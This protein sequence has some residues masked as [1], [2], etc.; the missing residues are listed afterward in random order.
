MEFFRR[1]GIADEIR[2]A[3]LPQDHPTDVVY[4]T[5]WRG[6]ELTRYRLPPSSMAKTK[7][8]ALDDSWPTPEPQHRICQIYL[9][10]ILRRKA[11]SMPGLEFREGWRFESYDAS[12][13]GVVA[14]V[15]DLDNNRVEEVHA[16]YLVG[17]E[18]ARSIVRS[19]MG[20]SFE[21]TPEVAR[22]LSTF[23]RCDRLAELNET[24]RGWMFR[25]VGR[26]RYHRFVAVDG[27]ALWIYHLTVGFDE[28]I[29]EL[30]P[31]AELID[32]IGESI[33]FEILGQVEWIGR[34]M[35]ANRFGDRNVFLAGDAA[36]IWIPMGGFGMNAGIAD[37]TNLSWK[38][39]AA[40]D[41]WGGDG[42]LNSYEAERKPIGE[43]VAKAAV[44]INADLMAAMSE[45][46]GV[47]LDDSERENARTRIGKAIADA[48]TTEFNS[49]GMQLGYCY[50]R[51]PI[52]CDD[53]TPAPAFALGAYT[54][55]S[56]PGA[57][58]PH[59]WLDDGRSLYDVL[60]PF[61]TLLQLG[62]SPP[63]PSPLIQ[64]ARDHQVPVE[65]LSLL[66][67]DALALYEGYQ[68]VMVRPD[69]HVAWRGHSPPVDPIAVIDSIRGVR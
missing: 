27:G 41:G 62:P 63:D 20:A 19:T 42:L 65:V 64:A 53:G 6:H 54:P 35:V 25:I 56:W 47:G 46:V 67:S 10:P 58:A 66:S 69:Q 24:W 32:A 43:L 28:D 21:G 30:D 8:G 52:V 22:T 29:D 34:A 23:I 68:L 17:A 9:E 2:A 57:R 49:V 15:R 38:L 36:H 55:T 4:L 13:D 1:L 45:A 7:S 14:T 51:S 39:T 26:E 37:A 33:D 3:G 12:H 59:L 44:G 40:V 11:K 48:N 18:G 61:F 60:G 5:Q 16:Q 50:E 31:S